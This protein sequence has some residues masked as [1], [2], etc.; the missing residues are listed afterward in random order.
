MLGKLIAYEFRATA[1]YFLPIYA[2][3]LLVSLLSG[4]LDAS[5]QYGMPLMQAI[6]VFSY[7]LLALALGVITPEEWAAIMDETVAQNVLG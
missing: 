7:T 1:R 6:L 2:A 3:L 4:L 5:S